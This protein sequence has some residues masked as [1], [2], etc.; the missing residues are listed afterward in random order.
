MSQ[1]PNQSL[2]NETSEKINRYFA[3]TR[4]AFLGKI[5]TSPM[6]WIVVFVY[7]L[8]LSDW[9]LYF[10]LPSD[11]YQYI[12]FEKNIFKGETDATRT[13]LY[14]SLINFFSFMTQE[15]ITIFPIGGTETRHFTSGL[16]AIWLVIFFQFT[17]FLV[18]LYFFYCN[19]KKILYNSN[20]AFLLTLRR[21][22]LIIRAKKGVILVDKIYHGNKHGKN[23]Y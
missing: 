1:N 7:L 5:I 15:K 22:A 13:P 9:S 18:A 4:F 10:T 11:T 19:I 3:N 16:N 23:K 20:L 6:F 8:F 21:P 17:F 14:P 2:L 12:S